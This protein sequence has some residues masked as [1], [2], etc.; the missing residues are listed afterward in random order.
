[1]F[2]VIKISPQPLREWD[3]WQDSN[4]YI[5]GNNSYS[6]IHLESLISERFADSTEEEQE[7][8]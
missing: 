2:S 6:P 4:F 5:F 7:E 8:E 3:L 1:M